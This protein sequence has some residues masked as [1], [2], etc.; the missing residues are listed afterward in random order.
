MADKPTRTSSI[1]AFLR[2][3]TEDDLADL[4]NYSME[5]QVNV[6]QDGGERVAGDYKGRKWVGWTDGLTTWKSFRI[7]YNA[8]KNPEYNDVSMSFDLAAHAEGIGMT[9]WDWA[10]RVSR[11]VAFDFDS[12]INHAEGLSPSELKEIVDAVHRIDWVTIRYSTSGNGYHLYVFL[13]E[14]PTETHTEH[15]ALARAILGQMSALVGIDFQS[16]V[17]GCGGNMWVWHRKKRGTSGLKLIKQGGILMDVPI[18]WRDHVKVITGARRKN[19]PQEIEESGEADSFDALS[20]QRVTIKLEPEHKALIEYLQKTEHLWWWD[21]DNQMLVT[22]TVILAK[23]HEELGLKGIFSTSSKGSNLNEQNCFAFPMKGGSWCVRRFTQGIQEEKTWQQDGQGWTR[24]YFNRD[25]DFITACRMHDG[26]KD[27]KGSYVFQDADSA[28]EALSLLG[29][30]PEIDPKLRCRRTKLKMSQENEVIIEVDKDSGDTQ[31]TMPGWLSEKNK[32]WTQVAKS[33]H[34]AVYEPET[35]NYDELIR[36]LVTGMDKKDR[37]WA[38]KANSVWQEEPKSNIKDYLKS[39]GHKAAEADIII[40][41]QIARPWAVVCKP[42]QPEFPGNREWNRNAAQMKFTPSDDPN[43]NHPTW[44]SILTRCGKGLDEAVLSNGWCRANGIG[45]GADYLKC[46]IAALF[47]H[48]DRPLPYIFLFGPQDS[49]KSSLFESISILLTTGVMDASAAMTSQASF[50]K[51]LEGKILCY[52]DEKDLQRNNQ[53]YN[54]IKEWVT[55]KELLIHGKGETPYTSPNY[56]HWIHCANDPNYCPVFPG[57][58]R[59]TM[60]YVDELD[61]TEMINKMELFIRLE[62]EA[63]DF[64]AS[65]LR[66]EIPP[67]NSRLTVPVVETTEKVSAQERNKNDLEVFIEEKCKYAPGYYILFSDLYDQFMGWLDPSES[68][69]W[70]KISFGKKVPNLYPKARIHGSAQWHFGNIAWRNQEIEDRAKYVV[71]NGYLEESGH[72]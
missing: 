54:K 38:M 6:A 34:R 35:A 2:A 53:A 56:T 59:I 16:K 72:D 3:S 33:S 20:G 22:H 55:A 7:P 5:V 30:R 13:P 46:W 71:E 19:L 70:G 65:I 69:N 11:W 1:E 43:L 32:P 37:G 9:G 48:P 42:F 21:N 23:A 51:E 62:K 50:N 49:G 64:L 10:S 28:L 60:T 17:D 25:A 27:P 36:H 26:I 67:S 52:I 57:D 8:A 58:T 24:C 47:Q 61:P 41:T 15:A 4:Y 68:H 63:P 39:L 40:G 66:L 45:K 18:N 29:I 14:I 31:V 44:D 12:I